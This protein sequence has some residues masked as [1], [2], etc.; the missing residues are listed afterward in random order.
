MISIYSC[1]HCLNATT[2]APQVT[3]LYRTYFRMVSS[4]DSD[5]QNWIDVQNWIDNTMSCIVSALLDKV[6]WP[7]SKDRITKELKWQSGAAARQCIQK[8]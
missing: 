4:S 3:K 7:K 2:L 5:F 6:A 8:Q 1:A